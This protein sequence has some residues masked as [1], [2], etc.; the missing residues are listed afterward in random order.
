[1][2]WGEENGDRKKILAQAEKEFRERIT[3]T[4]QRGS[5]LNEQL[6]D[7]LQLIGI[8][9]HNETEM[10]QYFKEHGYKAIQETLAKQKEIQEIKAKALTD[11]TFMKAPNGKDTNLTERQ[12]LQVRTNNCRK[13]FGDWLNYQKIRNATVIWGHPGTGKTWLHQQGRQDIIDFDSDYKSRLGSLKEREQLKKRIGK[14]AYNQELDK[15]FDDARQKAISTGKKLLVSDMHFLRDRV[16]DLD[17]ITNISDKEFIERSHQ[18]G[19]HDEADKMEWKNSIN[20]M[21]TN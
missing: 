10:A 17:A 12:W 9:V 20:E 2:R 19:E 15:L 13:W 8:D 3:A 4:K 5:A 16:N 6:L 14:Q 11:G 18:R 1:M 7:Y 21:I